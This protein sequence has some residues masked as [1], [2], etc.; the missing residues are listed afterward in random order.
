MS[1][2]SIWSSIMTYQEKEKLISIEL[3]DL[4]DSEERVFYNNDRGCH[5]FDYA[6]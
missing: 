1:N 3:V 5:K 4:V 2:K 6:S